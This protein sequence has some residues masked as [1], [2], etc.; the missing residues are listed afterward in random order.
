[1]YWD[2]YGFSSR[3]F[4]NPP[5]SGPFYAGAGREDLLRHVV[6]GMLEGRGFVLVCG[7]PGSGRSTMARLLA[8]RLPS[9]WVTVR[10]D[11]ATLSSA[12][13]V[14]RRVGHALRIDVQGMPAKELI[15]SVRD[16]LRRLDGEGGK[17]ALI[18]DNAERLNPKTIEGILW[19]AKLK[20]S[21][22]G[23]LRVALFS[24]IAWADHPPRRLA[25]KLGERLELENLTLRQGSHY[26]RMQ[27]DAVS[28][29]TERYVLGKSARYLIGWNAHGLPARLQKIA[30]A[31]LE[32][33]ASRG[34]KEVGL[35]DVV[36]A[37]RKHRSKAQLS[38]P[39]LHGLM[40]VGVVASL[41]LMGA[42][43]WTTVPALIRQ[44]A[45]SWF[46][47]SDSGGSPSTADAHRSNASNPAGLPGD[48]RLGGTPLDDPSMTTYGVPPAVGAIE[49]AM[50][51]QGDLPPLPEI[52]GVSPSAFG[53][54]PLSSQ[55]PATGSAAHSAAASSSTAAPNNPPPLVAPPSTR[56]PAAPPSNQDPQVC[57][58]WTQR[59]GG[60][61]AT[62]ALAAFPA[63]SRKE[64]LRLLERTQLYH[65]KLVT[66]E[67]LQ[68]CRIA[69]SGAWVV[70]SGHYPQPDEALSQLKRIE[71]AFPEARLLKLKQLAQ[72]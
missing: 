65:A 28:P 64:A 68:L 16:A 39:Q 15:A 36:V 8:L 22:R 2:H 11:G 58:A 45:S 43:A 30:D 13:S 60:D 55:R 50:Q 7:D 49:R 48:K 24:T 38:R 10:L 40:T 32:R 23:P 3:P 21:M 6:Q 53:D 35:T 44:G 61:D 54:R 4:I 19:L 72:S 52:D 62:V 1:M 51:W 31:S 29:G 27:L 9:S 25:M 63:D 56:P 67:S 12:G 59:H 20:P 14:F 46:A 71:A 37:S 69:G 42:W 34:A 57:A 33:A 5:M 66:P 41:L 47:A 70:I 18:V 17:I 26:L